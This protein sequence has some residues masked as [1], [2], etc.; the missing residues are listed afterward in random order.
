MKL[1]QEGKGD[2]LIKVGAIPR[3]KKIVKEERVKGYHFRED[4]WEGESKV[5]L[6]LK[7]IISVWERVKKNKK[8]FSLAIRH[9]QK[10]L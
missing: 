3:G 6:P 9:T 7:E 2:Y 1:F 5:L 10:L 4:S 8:D